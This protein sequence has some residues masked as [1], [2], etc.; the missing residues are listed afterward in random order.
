[1]T[2][3]EILQQLDDPE[4]SYQWEAVDAA[5]ERRHEITP[6]LLQRLEAASRDPQP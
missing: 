5:V 1:M 4:A 2:L 6:L 3:N